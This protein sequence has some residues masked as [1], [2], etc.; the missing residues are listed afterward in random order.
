MA[1][2]RLFSTGRAAGQNPALFRE[3]RGWG[4]RCPKSKRSSGASLSLLTAL[5]LFRVAHEECEGGDDE[6]DAAPV[7][8]QGFGL[9]GVHRL[10]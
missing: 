3:M 7:G 5:V 4:L 10:A 6:C 2:R 8:K 9:S 1:V